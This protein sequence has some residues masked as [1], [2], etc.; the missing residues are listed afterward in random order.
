[1]PPASVLAKIA[2]RSSSDPVVENASKSSIQFFD[3][4]LSD[5]SLVEPKG[6]RARLFCH[7][8]RARF[9]RTPQYSPIVFESLPPAVRRKM[10]SSHERLR[11]ALGQYQLGHGRTLSSS[12]SQDSSRSSSSR[13]KSKKSA[14]ADAF[15]LSQVDA[16]WFLN[17][18]ETVKRKHFTREERL[19][20][21]GR[22]Q[23]VIMDA[24]D[25]TIFRMG[26]QANRSCGT[27]DSSTSTVSQRTTADPPS[28]SDVYAKNDLS[29][30]RTSFRWLDEGDDLDLRLNIE[31]FHHS[32]LEKPL[33]RTSHSD[34]SRRRSLSLSAKLN[35]KP[36][37][38]PY[39]LNGGRRCSNQLPAARPSFPGAPMGS[40]QIDSEATYYQ[41]PEARLKLRVYLASAQK[42]D[43]AVEFGFP[44]NKDGRPATSHTG[45]HQHTFHL[46][47]ESFLDDDDVKSYNLNAKR[48][49]RS[50]SGNPLKPTLMTGHYPLT[51]P[52]SREMTLRMT[53]TRPDLR[54]DGG[55]LYGC[56]KE[57]PD[58]LALEPLPHMSDVDAG[59]GPF[60]IPPWARDEDPGL[61]RKLWRKVKLPISLRR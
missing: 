37:I 23:S 10:F 7:P 49:S 26:N 16:Q 13:G 9:D 14:P 27:L 25:E 40:M 52:G 34:H 54:A 2:G 30:W 47:D 48:L 42:F 20:L 51:S 41:D 44:S 1:M 31:E 57:A 19:L 59:M 4:N 46:Q 3:D 58:P 33:P 38:S 24:A 15:A 32:Y 8:K 11:M 50:I 18:P 55:Q 29:D 61:V 45:G 17:L 53:L 12:H 43:E 36:P 39:A 21:E 28:P 22:C 35:S 6:R 60:D 5:D 56:K